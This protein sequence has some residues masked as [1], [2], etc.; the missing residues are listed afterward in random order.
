M[1]LVK[2]NE[3]AVLEIRMVLDL[4]N[5]RHHLGRLKNGLEVFLE[6]VGNSNGLGPTRSLD[7]LQI[8]PLLLQILVVIGKER[9][10]DQIEINII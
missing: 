6:E 7:G 4:V 8:S 9:A 1:L 3:V 2:R 5:R 10:V